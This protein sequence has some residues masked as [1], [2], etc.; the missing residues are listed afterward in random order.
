[1]LRVPGTQ[2]HKYAPSRTVTLTHRVLT[3]INCQDML[4][5]IDEAHSRF[6]G[7]CTWPAETAPRTK[8]WAPATAYTFHV[9]EACL[10]RIDPD[11]EYSDWYRVA[12]AACNETGGDEVGYAKFDKWS[13]A[14][15]KY[16]GSRET[17]KVWQSLRLDHP[18]PVTLATLRYLVEAN[19]HCWAEVIAEAEPFDPSDEVG[20]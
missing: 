10:R 3:P 1:V 2:N 13:S 7:Q 9:L 19:G 20:E 16:R 8:V 12:A 11:L 4:Q 17:R 6:C 14:G 5:A 18:R 15:T